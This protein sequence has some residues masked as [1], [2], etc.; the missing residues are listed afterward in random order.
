M[1]NFFL[2]MAALTPRKALFVGLILT[3]VWYFALYNDGS[4]TQARLTIIEQDIQSEKAKEQESDLALKEIAAVQASLGSLSD[5]F[6]M[7]SAQ[8]PTDIQMAEIIR[9]VDKVSVATGLTVKSKEPRTSVKQD[10]I[11]ILPLRVS[12]NGTFAEITS[13]FYYLSTIERIVR[14]KSFKMTSPNEFRKGQRL[15]LDADVVSYKFVPPEAP[16]R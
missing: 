4:A 7:V 6:K 14:V 1:N 13:F 3:G 9:T 11:E 5:Q 16:K 8:L 2:R 12:A 10:L 15:S